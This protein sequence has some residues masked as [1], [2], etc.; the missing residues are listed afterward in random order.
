METRALMP[1]AISLVGSFCSLCND[2]C[3]ST[4]VSDDDDDDDDEEEE[5]EREDVDVHDDDIVVENEDIDE[6]RL[7]EGHNDN[8]SSMRQPNARASIPSEAREGN[9][10]K[11]GIF[12]LSC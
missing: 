9:V 6:E 5:E 10:K 11:L 7:Y 3:D 4:V 1:C 2:C 8:R 12:S